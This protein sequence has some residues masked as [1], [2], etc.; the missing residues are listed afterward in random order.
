MTLQVPL[1]PAVCAVALLVGCGGTAAPPTR[2][3]APVSV[4][5]DSPRIAANGLKFDRAELRFSAGRA[6]A[7]VFDNQEALPHNVSV[8]DQTGGAVFTGEVFT[9]PGQRVYAVPAL[10]PGGYS[11]LC[12]VH[13]DM[14]GT[15]TA[16]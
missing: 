6:F 10:P 9:G 15:A 16:Q 8:R 5:P 7:L 14:K 13:P 12:D 4:A 11:F 2:A 1:L 3:G